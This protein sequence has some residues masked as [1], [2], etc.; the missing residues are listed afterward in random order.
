VGGL[1]DG[2]RL[3]RAGVAA[4]AASLAVSIPAVAQDL[5]PAPAAP[6]PAAI[7]SPWP[8]TAGWVVAGGV[9]LGSFLLD[10]ET[11]EELY[12]ERPG[13]AQPLERIGNRFGNPLVGSSL[14]A[15][16]YAAGR[17]TGR[18]GLALASKRAAAGFLATGIVTQS[19]KWA[20]GRPRPELGP[21]SDELR[22]G[23]LDSDHQAWPSGHTSAAFSLAT[24]VAM[25]SDNAWVG[26][27]AYGLAGVT[28]W[29]R[30]AAD[31]H[32]TSDVVAGAV[33]GTLATRAT[34]RW[35]EARQAGDE[36]PALAIGPGG[37]TLT[38]TLP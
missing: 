31:R 15:L 25:E 35:L 6:V 19:L 33:V 38:L 2:S 21:D 12:L 8:S 36:T 22:P 27:L 3:H 7:A 10:Q 18:P 23:S 4:L 20:V 17:A 14:I 11:R 30:I 5:A 26:A 1:I 29:S 13:V 9:V 28:G 34:I 32:W 16:G 37:V 24:S